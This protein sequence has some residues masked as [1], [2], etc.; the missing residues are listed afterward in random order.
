MERLHPCLSAESWECIVDGYPLH[1]I[2]EVDICLRLP[3][4]LSFQI[5][6]HDV[7]H[8]RVV[9]RLTE[10]RAPALAAKRSFAVIG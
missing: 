5:G 9:A 4:E 3:I 1:S 8:V 10:Q 6:Q 2:A 7:N